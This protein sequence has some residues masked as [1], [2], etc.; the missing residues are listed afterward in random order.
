M[1]LLTALRRFK[2]ALRLKKRKTIAMAEAKPQQPKAKLAPGVS[3]PSQQDE[4]VAEEAKSEPAPFVRLATMKTMETHYIDF[5]AEATHHPQVL[6]IKADL[7]LEAAPKVY[8]ETR[9]ACVLIG[10]IRL[11]QVVAQTELKHEFEGEVLTSAPTPA[12]L[13][14]FCRIEDVA[15]DIAPNTDLSFSTISLP[16]SFSIVP[17]N[18]DTNDFPLPPT[19]EL[20][21]PVR[22]KRSLNIYD[23]VEDGYIGSGAWG[24]VHL[25]R[26]RKTGL[27]VAIKSIQKAKVISTEIQVLREQDTLRASAQRFCHGGNFEDFLESMGCPPEPLLKFFAAQLLLCL[28]SIHARGVVHRDL[29]PANLF[30][31]KNCHLVVGD[32]GLA[33]FASDEEACRQFCGTIEYVAR[34]IWRGDAFSFA[35]DVWA[36]GAVLFEMAVGRR[37]FDPDQFTSVQQLQVFMASTCLEDWIGEDEMSEDLYTFLSSIF[38][39]DEAT[40]PTLTT[41]KNHAFFADM[42][43]RRLYIHIFVLTR[44]CSDWVALAAGKLL[45][46]GLMSTD[47][48]DEE[49]IPVEDDCPYSD[50]IDMWGDE[51]P[52]PGFS[53]V[54]DVLA[55]SPIPAAAH[56]SAPEAN[57][58]PPSSLIENYS[59]APSSPSPTESTDSESGN[60]T[61]YD[62]DILRTPSPEDD[63]AAI[64]V[65]CTRTFEDI[66]LGSPTSPPFPCTVADNFLIDK[67]FAT[68]IPGTSRTA[69]GEDGHGDW[70]F[71]SCDNATRKR[72]SLLDRLKEKF[73]P[74]RRSL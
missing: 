71:P 2:T 32:F 74:H 16:E 35:S 11:E 3:P 68:D 53:F 43:A 57:R 40:R 50:G 14:E 44:Y 34:E 28:E 7:K 8:R 18:I 10:A 22:S 69:S 65:S 48:E 13:L 24:A 38:E 73:T 23:F 19:L 70:D 59:T 36:Y 21:A 6:S 1:T 4:V 9:V 62:S 66:P 55:F 26:H 54:S 12:P 33:T 51:D 46:P 47:D 45:C 63:I 25:A 52:F 5:L 29:K 64:I 67:P 49:L 37:L 61:S 72:R 27:Q 17:A 56:S 58:D 42:W 31:N 15:V 60:N 20:A 41:L 30:L 39:A